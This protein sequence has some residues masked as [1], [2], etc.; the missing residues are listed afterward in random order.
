VIKEME[1]QRH[2][3]ISITPDVYSHVLP[4][5]QEAVAENFGQIF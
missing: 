2:A 5:M 4:G 3:N 1:R